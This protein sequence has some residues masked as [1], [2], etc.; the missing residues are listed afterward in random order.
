M[1]RRLS[2]LD[3]FILRGRSPDSPCTTLFVVRLQW[4]TIGA[5]LFAVG[6]FG[7]TLY[8]DQR[9]AQ[10]ARQRTAE[11]VANDCVD[12]GGD[13]AFRNALADL[14]RLNEHPAANAAV[15]RQR[16][17][18]VLREALAEAGEPPPCV[19]RAP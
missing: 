12:R 5:V 9:A 17:A 15:Q 13:I 11:I 10:A 8:L 6:V 18:G 4:L 16:V 1:H 7:L 2:R 14:V 19:I 3:R